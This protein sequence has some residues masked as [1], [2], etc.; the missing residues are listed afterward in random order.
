ME[1]QSLEDKVIAW[2]NR[3]LTDNEN[4]IFT[5]I[6]IAEELNVTKEEVEEV[7]RKLRTVGYLGKSSTTEN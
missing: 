7:L 4:A 1:A 5:S 3:T 6:Q 2:V